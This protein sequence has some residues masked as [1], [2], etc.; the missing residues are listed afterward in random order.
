MFLSFV[1]TL[2][3]FL[4]RR[5][6]SIFNLEQKQNYLSYLRLDVRLTCFGN[7]QCSNEDDSALSAGK[8]LFIKIFELI[9]IKIFEFCAPFLGFL[10]LGN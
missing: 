6:D 7:V 2:K 4:L 3:T 5:D 8:F 9:F 1:K 10:Q